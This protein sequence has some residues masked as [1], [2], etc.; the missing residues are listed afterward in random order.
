MENPIILE[1]LSSRPIQNIEAGNQIGKYI[2]KKPGGAHAPPGLVG[3]PC[4]PIN[5]GPALV[6]S[7]RFFLIQALHVVQQLQ[8][9]MQ[10]MVHVTDR[11]IFQGFLVVLIDL[12]RGF[13]VPD[14]LA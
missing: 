7:R 11:E 12:G 3:K 9:V 8:Q 10:R 14:P 4:R 13:M 1:K 2:D 6:L 5:P